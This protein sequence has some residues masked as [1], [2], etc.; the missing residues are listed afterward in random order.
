MKEPMINEQALVTGSFFQI[1][2]EEDFSL[3][4]QRFQKELVEGQTIQHPLID[5]SVFLNMV[6]HENYFSRIEL[7]DCL[8][9]DCDFSGCHLDQGLF[10]RVVFRNCKFT[11]TVFKKGYLSNT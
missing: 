11:G 7:T 8:F 10:H 2:E 1:Y 6:F 3:M 4:Q 9:S 5:K